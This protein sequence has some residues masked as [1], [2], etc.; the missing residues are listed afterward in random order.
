M[1][2][3]DLQGGLPFVFL[4]RCTVSYWEDDLTVVFD[5]TSVEVGESQKVLDILKGLNGLDL[6]N[7]HYFVFHHF[8]SLA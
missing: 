7:G 8:D 5:E 4:Q 3:F 6:L 1:R 2:Q